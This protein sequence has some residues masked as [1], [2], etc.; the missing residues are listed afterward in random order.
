[1]RR[2]AFGTFVQ[3]DRNRDRNADW[4]VAVVA[5]CLTDRN[6]NQV[7]SRKAHR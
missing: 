2:K 7:R 5:V 3:V 6:R 4:L 1:M